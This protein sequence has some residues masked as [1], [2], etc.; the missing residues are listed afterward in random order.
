LRG[1]VAL[2]GEIV[3]VVDLRRRFALPE[4]ELS[5]ESRILVVQSGGD[6]VAGILVEAVLEV[7]HFA[8]GAVRAADPGLVAVRGLVE[9]AGE[10]VSLLDLDR[11]LEVDVVA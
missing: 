8:P 9:R 4:T 7:A 10:S 6:A 1:I 11:L 5:A 3:Q 2:R